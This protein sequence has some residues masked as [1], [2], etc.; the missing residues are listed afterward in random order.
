MPLPRRDILRGNGVHGAV[1]LLLRCKERDSVSACAE[2][3]WVSLSDRMRERGSCWGVMGLLLVCAAGSPVRL[4]GQAGT[5]RAAT[6]IR[7]YLQEAAQALQEN[8]PDVAVRDYQAI[9]RTNPKNVDAHANLGVIAF[10]QKDWTGAEKEFREVLKLQPSLWKAKA[11]LGLCE[12]HLGQSSDAAKLLSESFPHLDEPKLRLEA[13]LALTEIWYQ[14]GDLAQASATISD[15]R[16]SNPDNIAVLFAAYRIYTDQSFQTVDAMALVGPDSGQ[17]HQALAEHQ[18][19]EGHMEAAIIEYQK[20]IERMPN[21]AGL[22]YEL[23]EAL[24]QESHVEPG[25]T[26]AQQEFERALA[27]NPAD[28][29]SE[30]ELAKIERLRANLNV[31][32]DYYAGAQKINPRTSCANLGLAGLLIDEGKAQEALSYLQTAVEIDPYDPEIRWRLATV[33]RQLGRNEDAARELT[34]F[35]ELRKVRTRMQ[36]SYEQVLPVK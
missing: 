27:L 29:T 31:A 34:A 26:K 15:L 18:V 19:N 14:A 7:N 30:C 22:H 6:D 5:P 25:L 12:V 13:G 8:R 3:S 24:L 23:G 32:H 10:V 17:L 4:Y 16:R 11:L 1:S 21:L 28:S 35:Q 20:A 36:K 2:E 9:L 33:Y